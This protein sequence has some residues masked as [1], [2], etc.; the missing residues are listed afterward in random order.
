M[1]KQQSV[2]A[3]NAQAAWDRLLPGRQEF[4]DQAVD[5]A[6][7]TIPRLVPESA[8]GSPSSSRA[9]SI[10]SLYQGVG[11][12]G[13]SQLANKLVVT[14]LPPQEPYFRMVVDEAVVAM[15]E[16]QAQVAGQPV[17]QDFRSKLDAALSLNEQR[18]M[19][20]M[21]RIRIRSKLSNGFKHLVVAGNLLVYVSPTGS[22][23]YTLPKYVADVDPEGNPVEVVICEHVSPQVLRAMK[24]KATVGEEDEPQKVFTHIRWDYARNRVEWI[25][26]HE[27]KPIPDTFGFSS[28]EE[29]PWIL[30]ATNRIDGEAYGRAV[31]EEVIGDLATHNELSRAV[32]EA[33]LQMAKLVW[34]VNPNGMTRASD[35]ANAGNGD[36]VA[37]SDGDV[38][39]LSAGEK[40]RDVQ[41]A[42]GV[43][44]AVER[45]LTYSFAMTEA[46]QRDAERVTAEE[47]RLMAQQL[48]AGMAGLYSDLS[49]QLQLPLLRAVAG[50]MAREN[51]LEPMPEGLAQPQITSGLD[52]IGRGNEKS[53]LVS[54]IGS[55]A[56]LFGADAIRYVNMSE[57][58]RR[59]AAAEGVSTKGLIYTDQELQ[60][61]AAQVQRDNMANMVTQ[62]VINANAQPPAT[63]A[64]AGGPAQA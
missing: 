12:R 54:F 18:I 3:S 4:L 35:I 19:A 60:A 1:S 53:R 20:R 62:G 41:A 64:G 45:R 42:A 58:L 22:R 51:Q 52:A 25:Q 21:N 10:E 57:W 15:F 47:V 26:Q 6:S 63:G 31:V 37:G 38:T 43:L 8:V 48:D 39:A 61:Q 40:I 50:Q 28:I 36:T 17:D 24:P 5:N 59:A 29:C 13:V 49:D 55:S 7:L 33:S 11:S 16:Q 9:E 44:S 30:L 56:Q 2:K 14:L 46:V 23:C 27:E 34:L 32:V